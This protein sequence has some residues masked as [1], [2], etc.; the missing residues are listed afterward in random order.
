MKT[1]SPSA[2]S[3]CGKKNPAEVHTCTP[4]SEQWDQMSDQQKIEWLAVNIM[5][6]EKEDTGAPAYGEC[7][8]HCEGCCCKRQ[9]WQRWWKRMHQ[10]KQKGDMVMGDVW[11]EFTKRGWNPFLDWNHT[12]EMIAEFQKRGFFYEIS[13]GVYSEEAWCRLWDR[14][15]HDHIAYGKQQQAICKAA[16]LSMQ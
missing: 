10:P 4:L 1:E 5:N 14:G 15:F 11:T 9:T 7:D 6:W 12:M 3:I 16:F 2:C 8:K 13:N